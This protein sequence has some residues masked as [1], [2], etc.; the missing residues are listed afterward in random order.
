[1]AKITI[2]YR[3]DDS[4]DITGRIFDRLTSRYGREAVF[5]D[6]DSIPPGRDFREHIRANLGDS[7]VLMV[8]VGPRWMGGDRNGK[9][10]IHSETDYVRTEV[11][12]A[13][14]RHIPVIPLLIGGSEMPEPGDLPESIRDFAY[15]NAVPIDSG[16]DFDHHMNGLIRATDGI[17][18]GAHA[19]SE[20]IR[21]AE[22]EA[23]GSSG[24]APEV[25]HSQLNL[26]FPAVGAAMTAQGLIHIAWYLTNLATA[27]A[28]GRTT[29][30]FLQV[31]SYA[32]MAF[33][34]GGLVV[35][36]GT[37]L[38]RQWAR[39]GGVM[40]CVLASLSNFLWF[41]EFFDKPIPRLEMVGTG[42]A[43]LMFIAGAYLYLFRWPATA[44]R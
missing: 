12:I 22:P 27:S 1:M 14:S 18:H 33:G 36:V 19:P 16:R 4:M 39:A 31:W 5:R 9:A 28:A 26:F 24:A 21:R 10:R 40:L 11:E 35:G 30:L 38:R 37:I 44:N 20:G 43:L 41:V 32:D 34:F 42:L 13:L 8:V 6:I 17:L 3:R 15:R 7:D 25:A 29:E 23:G 2:S